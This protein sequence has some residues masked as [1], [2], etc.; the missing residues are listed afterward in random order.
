MSQRVPPA[1]V[2]EALERASLHGRAAAA[3]AIA[4]CRALL[5]AAALVAVARPAGE[6][7]GL[8]T[9][10][11]LL[12]QLEHE[13]APDHGA[14]QRFAAPLMGALA[15]A[16]DVEIARWERRARHDP[17]A[18]AVLRA[19]LGIR[20]L[21]WELGVRVEEDRAE[22]RDEDTPEPDEDAGRVPRFRV[23]G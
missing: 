14:S 16:L 5:D 2:E 10:D 23:H 1:S 4:A 21:L 19:F 20:E 13:L 12:E 18:R 6:T 17:D 11:A 22:T 8:A 15:E 9:A 7:T 3:E